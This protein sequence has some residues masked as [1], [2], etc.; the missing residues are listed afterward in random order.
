MIVVL[1]VKFLILLRNIFLIFL[2]FLFLGFSLM[3]F[4]DE[5]VVVF[6]NFGGLFFMFVMVGFE[7]VG[8]VWKLK[9]IWFNVSLVNLLLLD[10]LIEL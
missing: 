7:F 5:K 4:C 1:L 2:K 3:S 9:L 8:F 10:V 6:I